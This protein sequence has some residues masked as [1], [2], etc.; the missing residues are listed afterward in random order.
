MPACFPRWDGHSKAEQKQYGRMAHRLLASS[1]GQRIF[2]LLLAVLLILVGAIVSYHP[3]A[4]DAAYRHL[5]RLARVPGEGVPV[6]EGTG[7]DGN[8]SQ[9]FYWNTRG[10]LLALPTLPQRSPKHQ[11]TETQLLNRI[12]PQRAAYVTVLTWGS[13]S[14]WDAGKGENVGQGDGVKMAVL[15]WA[16]NLRLTNPKHDLVLLFFLVDGAEPPSAR[17]QSPKTFN[18]LFA[19]V[20]ISIYLNCVDFPGPRSRRRRPFQIFTAALPASSPKVLSS[21]YIVHV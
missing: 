13:F 8:A 12:M 5:Q 14:P 17:H 10:Q 15:T 11:L 18:R 9:L 1:N 16:Y 6:P 19:R 21:V 2:V 7:M 3:G 4:Q 20:R